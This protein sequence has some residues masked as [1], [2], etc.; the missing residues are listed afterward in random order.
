MGEQAAYMRPSLLDY[1]L[2]SA[3]VHCDIQGGWLNS[4]SDHDILISA[5]T[6]ESTLK[7]YKKTTFVKLYVMTAASSSRRSRAEQWA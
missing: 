5:V 1:S 4:I 6:F 3:V 7:P 2:H